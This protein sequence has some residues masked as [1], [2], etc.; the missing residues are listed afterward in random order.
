MMD[1]VTVDRGGGIER[2]LRI[3]RRAE[4]DIGTVE[5][6]LV[7]LMVMNDCAQDGNGGV[8]EVLGKAH[9]LAAE[10][11]RLLSSAE[12]DVEALKVTP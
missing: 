9:G 8:R 12:K 3:L 11:D 7:G 10:A 5:Y 6:M 2:L 1:T 4:R